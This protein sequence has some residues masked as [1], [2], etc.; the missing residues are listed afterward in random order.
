M[1]DTISIADKHWGYGFAVDGLMRTE[2]V[3][4]FL[5]DI[6]KDTVKAIAAR[7]HIRCGRITGGR[8][9]VYCR[10]SVTEYARSLET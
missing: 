3:C 10:R 4:K 5:G 9:N 2:D 8:A 6:H 7:G 1:A